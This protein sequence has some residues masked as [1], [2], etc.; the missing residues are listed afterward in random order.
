MTVSWNGPDSMSCTAPFTATIISAAPIS[1]VP[2][3]SDRF[4]SA[5]I[6]DHRT[7][8]LAP[9]LHI[10]TTLRPLSVLHG[11]CPVGRCNGRLCQGQKSVEPS[12]WPA[13]KSAPWCGQYRENRIICLSIL[14]AHKLLDTALIELGRSPSR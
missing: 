1:F 4:R 14:A 10:R 9:A 12:K 6:L 8:G 11:D 2:L 5:A 13:L 3:R 7:Q